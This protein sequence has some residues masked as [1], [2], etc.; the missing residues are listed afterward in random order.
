MIVDTD[1]PAVRTLARLLAEHS[2]QQLTAGRRWRIETSLRPLLREAKLASLNELVAAIEKDPKGPLL[3]RTLDLMLNHE[4]SFFRDPAVFASLARDV[5]PRLHVRLAHRRLRIWCAGCSTGQEAYSIAMILRRQVHLWDGWDIS[6]LATD[7]SPIAIDSAR[8][9]HFAQREMQ[10]GLPIAELLRWFDQVG[11]DW[12]AR[13][14]LRDM[15]RFQA[16]NL[17]APEIVDSEFDLILCR[18]VLLYFSQDIRQRACRILGDRASPGSYLVLGAGETI[19]GQDNRFV[20]CPDH[21]GIY[22]ARPRSGA[23]SGV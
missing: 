14:E 3:T 16:D 12:Q 4:S 22:T 13:D 8:Q 7:V 18:N 20:P 2:G 17:L 11:A 6:I 1:P 23:A 9:G 10:R 19:M 15:I 5:L 21:R